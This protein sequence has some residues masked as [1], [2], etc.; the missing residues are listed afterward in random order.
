MITTLEQ[1]WIFT[2]IALNYHL[3]NSA[4]KQSRNGMV[5]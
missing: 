2:F 3:A 1:N 5:N 4:L